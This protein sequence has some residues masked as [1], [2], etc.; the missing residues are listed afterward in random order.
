MSALSFIEDLSRPRGGREVPVAQVDSEDL[1]LRPN[2]EIY[3]AGMMCIVQHVSNSH[4]EALSFSGARIIFD[5][6]SDTYYQGRKE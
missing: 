1:R 5:P 4:V 6:K 2:D 3:W